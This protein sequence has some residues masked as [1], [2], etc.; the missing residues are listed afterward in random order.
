MNLS[1][2]IILICLLLASATARSQHRCHYILSGQLTDRQN[3]DSLAYATIQ[4][5]ETGQGTLADEHG[6]FVLKDICKGTYT[7]LVSYLGY[8][9]LSQSITINK[10]VYHTFQ[11]V[12]QGKEAEEIIIKEKKAPESKTELVTQDRA[13]LSGRDLERTRGLTLGES[14]KSIPGVNS[15]QTGPAISKPMIHGLHS[16]RILILNNGVR[17]EGQQWGSEHAPEIDPFIA[18]KISVIKGA[19]SIRYGSDAI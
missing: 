2:K 7:V 14:L 10:D 16:N 17:Q 4:L 13:E 1:A 11:L 19:A 5:K 18:T 12:P 9:T 3:G 15:L 8:D 6:Y